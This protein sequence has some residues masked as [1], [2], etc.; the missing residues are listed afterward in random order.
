MVQLESVAGWLELRVTDT[1]KGLTDAEQARIFTP[2]W[3]ADTRLPG[4]GVGLSITA[5]LV[6]AHGGTIA[7]H[8][9]G[10]GLGTTFTVRLPRNTPNEHASDLGNDD[11]P[12]ET[13]ASRV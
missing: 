1:G 4:L 9:D 13:M 5:S 8:S 10:P 12:T 11:T 6:G 7:V 3:R 2:F